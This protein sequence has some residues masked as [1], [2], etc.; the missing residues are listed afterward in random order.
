MGQQSEHS[1]TASS[2]S[3]ARSQATVPTP[4]E[5]T[6]FSRLDLGR[7]GLQT[8][9]HDCW[10]VLGPWG[11]FGNSSLPH[12]PPIRLRKLCVVIL[13]QSKGS[14]RETDRQT[15]AEMETDRKQGKQDRSLILEIIPHHLTIFYSL[16]ASHLVQPTLTLH[17]LEY[18]KQGTSGRPQRLPTAYSY[19]HFLLWQ[20]SP[21]TSIGIW[22][23][24]KM[25]LD[26]FA[27]SKM[28]RI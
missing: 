25:E 11:M 22:V 24:K 13:L 16:K 3:E 20:G 21:F 19:C 26:R 23:E 15:A 27:L 14:K 6:V 7:P 18:Q 4:A 1:W 17:W 10:W 8:H 12:G 9:S 5:A 2:G 28:E